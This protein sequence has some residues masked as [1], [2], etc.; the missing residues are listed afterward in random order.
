MF[1]HLKAPQ[2]ATK[3]NPFTP[4][5]KFITMSGTSI[6]TVQVNELN[7]FYRYAGPTNAPVVPT[8]A[9]LSIVLAPVSK[10]YPPSSGIVSRDR[11]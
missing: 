6:A 9:W 3:T 7:V 4:F 5:R 11:S 2:H 8:S 1:Q 10:P